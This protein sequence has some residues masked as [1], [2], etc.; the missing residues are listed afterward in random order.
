M[1]VGHSVPVVFIILAF[2][3]PADCRRC[4]GKL[5]NIG[6][7]KL[8]FL[9]VS[10]IH[11]DPFYDKSSD[12]STWCHRSAGSNSSADYEAPYGRIGCDSPEELWTITLAG[13]KKKEK[14]ANFIVL[15]GDS[16]A[17]GLTDDFGSPNV[18]KSMSLVSSKTHEVFPDIPVF[19][20]FGNNDLPGHYILP[21]NSD[22]YRTV[23]SYW[24]PLI[25]CAEC[26]DNVPRPTSFEALNETFM[27]GGYYSV[28]I[29]DGKMILLVLNT[30][31]WNDNRYTDPLVDQIADNQMQWF[32]SQLQMAKDQGKKVL[33]MSHIPAG[34]DPFG[35][36]FFWRP[37]YLNRYV[38]L[39]AGKYHDIVAGK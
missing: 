26:P 21:N 27:D 2:T 25:L 18:L 19:P 1:H 34:G 6:K 8:K 10:D 36:A 32:S 13:M 22:W 3:L 14:N 5:C 11:L 4:R 16:S 9:H 33:I 30:M 28:N 37:E 24:A 38:S 29:A 12:E 23:L 7:N 15:S 31:Y 20:A 35:Y 17:H 39:V